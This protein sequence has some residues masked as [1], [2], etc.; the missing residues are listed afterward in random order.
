[1]QILILKKKLSGRNG[2]VI[3][4]TMNLTATSPVSY[5]MS[6]VGKKIPS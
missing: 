3:N 1:M 2:K 6:F 4:F 5:S